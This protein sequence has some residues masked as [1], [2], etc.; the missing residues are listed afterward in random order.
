MTSS[1][2]IS[3]SDA[4]DH[5]KNLSPSQRQTAEYLDA[6]HNV[7]LTGGGGV[8][9]SY[10]LKTVVARLRE[11]G[12]IVAV[13][14]STG[15]AADQIG[16]VT[17]HSLLGLGLANDSLD[18]LTSRALQ[19]THL[20]NK[21]N[22]LNILVIDEI[23]M[24]HPEFFSVVDHIARSL[25]KNPRSFG[26]LQLLLCGDFFQLPPVISG[27]RKASD[28]SFCFQTQSWDDAALRTVILTHTFRQQG[29]TRFTEL[30]NR[31]RRGE[32]TL[33]D[34]DILANRM[35][36][37]LDNF[38]GIEPTR[39]HSRRAN[40]DE[41]NIKS[42]HNLVGARS[43]TYL[44]NVYWD[45]I[46]RRVNDVETTTGTNTLLRIQQRRRQ[47]INK[48]QAAASIIVENAPARPEIELRIG[49]Q[50]MLLCNLDTE[51]G[52]VNGSRGIVIDFSESSKGKERVPIVQFSRGNVVTVE[53]YT[54]E[55]IVPESGSVFYRQIPLQLAWAVTIHKAQGLSL[56][57]VEISLDRSVFEFGQA[58]VA[59]SRVRSLAGLRL[60]SFTS[61]VMNAHP[62]VIQFYKN[63]ESE[64]GDDQRV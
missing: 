23:S 35:N 31:V 1:S 32:Y 28:L 37:P 20:R 14:A 11:R 40:V 38:G 59:L 30:L 53:R 27:A 10:V 46:K 21:W 19:K 9:K 7:F 64:L 33:D 13:T 3:S 17:L 47:H 44:S 22:K 29:D 54:W 42:L 39:M 4:I 18:K 60:V 52:L 56:D 12:K 61:S 25:R 55:H 16:G 45:V 15:A 57:C 8:G 5:L 58:Y 63:L 6:G 48:L 62:L 36:A 49:A 24:L 26:G 34:V 51:G 43:E 50:V 2:S 41:I